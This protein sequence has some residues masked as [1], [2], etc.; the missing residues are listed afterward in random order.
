M[1]DTNGN[2]ADDNSSFPCGVGSLTE[3]QLATA[4]SLLRQTKPGPTWLA[5][6]RKYRAAVAIARV[7][8]EYLEIPLKI[9]SIRWLADA[10][11]GNGWAAAVERFKAEVKEEEAKERGRLSRADDGGGRT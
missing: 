3:D 6:A 10:A 2:W 5:T 8:D 1:A 4:E 9:V 7:P 11:E